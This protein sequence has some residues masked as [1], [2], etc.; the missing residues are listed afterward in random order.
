MFIR[1]LDRHDAGV[2]L[3]KKLSSYANRENLL[4]LGLPRGGVPVAFEV[5]KALKAPLDVFVVRK[6]GAPHQEELAIGAVA[7]GG[8]SYLNREILGQLRIPQTQ[9]DTILKRESEAILQKE[10][11]YREFRPSLPLLH[12]TIILIDDGVATGSTIMAALKAIRKH[13]PK[14]VIVAVP[15]T[16]KNAET[17]ISRFADAF[18]SAV[19]TD[20]FTSVGQFYEDFSPTQDEEVIRLLSQS[21]DATHCN[22]SQKQTSLPEKIPRN[23]LDSYPPL[24]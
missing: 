18:V 17:T 12:Q 8:I 2:A 20:D 3:A 24:K 22:F 5:A 4:V 10:N 14:T 16:S 23:L 9:I 11:R 19:S 6:L 13:Q 15:V 7:S 21:H 1:F